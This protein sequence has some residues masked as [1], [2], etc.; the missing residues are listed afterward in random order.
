VAVGR[1]VTP[2]TAED[3]RSSRPARNGVR[4]LPTISRAQAQ[5]LSSRVVVSHGRLERRV[6]ASSVMKTSLWRAAAVLAP[7][8]LMVTVANAHPGHDGHEL[9]WD[10][11]HLAQHPLATMG[12]AAVIG[13]SI[14][15]VLFALRQRRRRV[16]NRAV[17]LM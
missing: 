7:F 4:A 1:A 16:Q 15:L 17:R 6:L 11:S 14:G 10:F 8:I 13:A 12:C 9:T 2:L 5:A 3:V